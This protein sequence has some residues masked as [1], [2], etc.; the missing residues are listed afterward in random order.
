M[1]AAQGFL[2]LEA[3]SCGPKSRNSLQIACLQGIWPGDRCDQD[4][5]ASQAV[6][7]LEILPL[8]MPEMPA[9]SGLLR[10]GGSSLDSELGRFR[11]EIAD[12]LR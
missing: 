3:L 1:P 12:S 5:V 9:N 7:L 6:R 8:V 11:S 10:I 4:C 2:T